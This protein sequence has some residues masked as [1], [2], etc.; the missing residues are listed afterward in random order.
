MVALRPEWARGESRATVACWSRK[1]RNLP[2]PQRYLR[3]SKIGS[4]KI[5]FQKESFWGEN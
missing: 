1:L 3:L 5:W 2:F 4:V